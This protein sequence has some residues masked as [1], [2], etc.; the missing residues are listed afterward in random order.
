MYS[1]FYFLNYK[2]A[3][4]QTFGL[5]LECQSDSR[6]LYILTDCSSDDA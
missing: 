3:N 6:Y 5:I 4:K 2:K 1:S